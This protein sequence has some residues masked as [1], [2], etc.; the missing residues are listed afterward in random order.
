MNIEHQRG[1]FLATDPTL[2]II[3]ERVVELENVSR[4][5]N[6]FVATSVISCLSLSSVELKDNLQVEVKK[7]KMMYAVII[8]DRIQSMTRTLVKQV[9]T[10]TESLTM[11]IVTLEDLQAAV[12]A[13][14]G[15]RQMEAE[16][17]PLQRPIKAYL[18]LL[19]EHKLRPP[20][21]DDDLSLGQLEELWSQ[22]RKLSSSAEDQIDLVQPQFK[23]GLRSDVGNFQA[24][25]QLFFAVYQKN[26]PMVPS[27]EP[28]AAV[29]RLRKTKTEF[30]ELEQIWRS[31]EAGERL[32]GMPITPYAELEQVAAELALLSSLYNLYTDVL[33]TIDGYGDLLWASVDCDVMHGQISLFT[34]RCRK[35]NKKMKEWPAFVELKQ[36]ID[37]F[38]DLL[39]LL[40]LLRSKTLRERHWITIAKIA[41]QE[42]L[43]R[44]VDIFKLHHVLELNMV[45]N[46]DDVEEIC[47]EAQKQAEIEA[48]LARLRDDWTDQ[49]FA[50][51][52]FKDRGPL[53]L[54]S[55]ATAELTEKLDESQTALLAMMASRFNG[56]F[57]SSLQSWVQK[58]ATVSEVTEQWLAVQ[59]LWMYLEAVFSSGDI[60]KQ[61]P[62]ESRRFSQIDKTWTTIMDNASE[63]SNCARLCCGDE[64]LKNLLPSLLLQLEICQRHL[65]GYL[66][67][68]RSIFPRFY[69]ISDSALLEILGRGSDATAIQPHL[70]SIFDGVHRVTFTASTTGHKL[71]A[72][73]LSEQGEEIMLV[74]PVEASGVVEK[75][76]EEL[77]STMKIT[78][79]S[80]A[81]TAT[82]VVADL[83]Q[84]ENFIWI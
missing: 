27:L 80:V 39:P 84:L 51:E 20:E 38:N 13:I 62:Q 9:D 79:K 5:I 26:G 45:K 24:R 69:F 60:A 58:L 15:L 18:N 1:K 75:W 54:E 46:G 21:M 83:N 35:L 72:A 37:E 81:K 19:A 14:S 50:F 49:Y 11:D 65:G 48:R 34:S 59:F 17:E 57:K 6:N 16:M 28:R 71:I 32:F 42:P 74:K 73:L 47:V 3:E 77:E 22:A 33:S 63:Q 66:E 2:E 82:A 25:V 23:S 8:H 10:A 52:D 41:G 31:L 64:M 55:K 4:Q 36:K 40:V 29:E 76:L 44:N 43:N 30:Q 68:K 53:L 61:L 67:G 56:P 70:Q 7:W 78:I 12:G